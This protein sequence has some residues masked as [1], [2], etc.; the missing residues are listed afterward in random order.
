MF[1]DPIVGTVKDCAIG[2][3]PPPSEWTVC[4]TEGGVCAFTGAREVR[5]GV[6]G[7]F[8]YRTLSDGTAC[9]NEVFGDPIY[10]SMKYCATRIPPPP[11]D[12]TFCAAEGGVCA[13]TGTAEVR[14]G[15]NGAYV[16][17]TLA[18]GTACTNVVFGDPLYGVVKSCDLRTASGSSLT[19]R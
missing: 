3:T 5:Y 19:S 4:A 9:T 16:Y 11:T 13:F 10:G 1:G 8:V 6:N 15:A 18:N 7:A 17:Q 14:Y 12:W 2:S